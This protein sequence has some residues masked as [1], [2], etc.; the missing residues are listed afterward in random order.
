ML[1]FRECMIP[2]S[3]I[4]REPVLFLFKKMWQFAKGHRRWVVVFLVMSAISNLFL[5]AQPWIFGEF[6][7][8]IQRNGFGEHNIRSLVL[9]LVS[10]LGLDLAFWVFHGPSRIIENI[11][12]FRTEQN[13][14][15]YLLSGVLGLG[16]SWHATRDSGDTID[17]VNKAS[18]A[19]YRFSTH[20]FNVVQVLMKAIGTTLVLVYFHATIG[21]TALVLLVVALIII[22]QFDLRLIPQYKQLNAFINKIS[23]RIFDALSNIT[24]VKVL[25]IEK[26]VF[27]GIRESLWT[28]LLLF[29]KNKIM[30]EAKWF[31]GSIMFTLIVVLPLL[32]Y[33]LNLY[34]NNLAIE[35][36]TIS[37][38]YLYLSRLIDVYFTFAAEYE[39]MIINKTRVMNAQEIEEAIAGQDTTSRKDTPRWQSLHLTNVLFQY[40]DEDTT[41]PQINGV[42]FEIHRGQSVAVIGESGSGK[43]TFLKVIHGMYPTASARIAFDTK[44]PQGTTFADIDLKTTLV[45]QEPEVFSASIR[46]NITLGLD[47]GDKAIAKASDLAAFTSVIQQLPK[48]LDSVINEKGVNL[49]GGQKQRLAL[50]R[51]LLFAN[52]KEIILLD[53]STSSVDPETEV[54]IYQNIFRYFK[55][56]TILASIH[57]MNLLKYFDWIVIFANGKIVD[58]G[59]F[60]ELLK[61]NKKFKKDWEEYVAH[62]KG[63]QAV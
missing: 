55:G 2:N 29:K 18:D 57:K 45:P 30:I 11:T 58:Q 62:G 14:R 47:Y 60:N 4:S 51:A 7:N 48:G 23:A 28:P 44:K 22:F 24:T 17:K 40:E 5:L 46:E 53:E 61:S 13:Y 54:N 3:K 31:V 37:A 32:F 33:I 12:G 26:P 43:T 19:L 38:L 35:V 36:G 56:K 49:S 41:A 59:T 39:E 16:L 52:E 21:L 9:I 8:E 10:L 25:H 50:T 34:R 63:E 42:D 1:F 15:Q 20:V 27:E 6:L